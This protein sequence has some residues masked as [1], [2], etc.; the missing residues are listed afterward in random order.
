MIAH[1]HSIIVGEGWPWL[2]ASLVVTG[3]VAY[4]AGPLWSLL[5]LFATV[6]LYLLFRDPA[7]EVP[8]LPLAVVAPV[9]GRVVS[10]AQ[11]ANQNLPGDWQCVTIRA[12]PLG[13]YTV[14]AP[15][16]GTILDVREKCRGTPLE[17][18]SHG[19]W[20][21]SEEGDDVVLLFRGPRLFRP[22]TFVRYG[23]RVGQGA[24]FA[25]LRLTP[26]AEL[27]L[28]VSARILAQAGDRVL[29]GSGVIAELV[30]G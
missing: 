27:Y 16:E 26:T 8:P 7:R 22:R 12:N 2:L 5:P 29:A 17:G 4:R 10:T 23:E 11:V 19:M 1:R 28:P 15:I 21:L 13:A 24:R 3:L 9:D 25:Y 20:L 14:R 6:C 30:H 18:R